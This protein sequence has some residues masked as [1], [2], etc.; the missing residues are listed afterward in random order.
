MERQTFILTNTKE[1]RR[2]M[3]IFIKEMDGKIDKRQITFTTEH[4]VRE[5]DRTTNARKVAAEYS[6]TDP[7]LI[8]GMYRDTGYGK[9][10]VHKDDPNAERKLTA[11]NVTPLDTEKI[12]LRNLFIGAGM[13]F[14]DKKDIKVLHKEYQ[15]HMTAKAGVNIDGAQSTAKSIPSEQ[16]DVMS[17]I[18]SAIEAAKAKYVSEGKDW[19][20]LSRADE[21]AFVDG[22]NTPDFDADKFLSGKVSETK[23]DDIWPED[24]E[25]MRQ[26]YHQTLNVQVPVPKKNDMEWMKGKIQEAKGQ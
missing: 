8:D 12:A 26:L 23:E 10:F 21:L 20:A 18:N 4:K 17:S 11:Y 16:V 5:Q 14:D 15:I 2:G 24:I 6:T 9:T 13:E 25:E 22:L 1:Y 3:T 7:K 19:P